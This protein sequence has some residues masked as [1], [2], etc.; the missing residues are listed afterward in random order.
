[1]PAWSRIP[2]LSPVH[3]VYRHHVTFDV[4]ADAYE[5]F[6]GRFS[7]PLAPAFCDATLRELDGDARVLDVGCGPG[8]LTGELVR[9][10]RPENVTAIDPAPPFVAT[11]AERFPAAEVR[12]GRAEELPFEDGSF[13][14]ALG[15][16]VVL[17]LT[18]PVRGLQEM[19]R[20]TRPGGTVATC[21]WDLAGGPSPISPFWEVARRVD[22]SAPTEGHGP[23][24]AEGELA[25]LLRRAGLSVVRQER[26]SVT[27]S[28]RDFEDWWR[29]FTF[30]V[31]PTGGYVRGLSADR[32][33]RLEDA[34]RAELPTGPFEREAAAWS[35]WGSA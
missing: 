23:G 8:M 11:T 9:R 7:T 31:G 25:D 12:R 18:D 26:L 29:P 32:L 2:W 4:P 14:A 35:A 34:L 10:F 27:V 33:R 28:F 30:G 13:D 6:L 19:A 3:T 24:T 16:L 5:R 20:V 1:M 17:A 21:L 22:P 15:Q